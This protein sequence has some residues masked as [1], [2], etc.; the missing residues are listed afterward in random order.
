MYFHIF[1]V[2]NNNIDI[3]GYKCRQTARGSLSLTL[4]DTVFIRI[5]SCKMPTQ[6][7]ARLSRIR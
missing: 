6:M 4:Y 1:A 5:I 7:R 3:P 2:C